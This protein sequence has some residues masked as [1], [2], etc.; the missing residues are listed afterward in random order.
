[1][2]CTTLNALTITVAQGAV[3]V[4]G[5]VTCSG[6]SATFTP[7]SPLAPNAAF[8]AIVTTGAKDLAGVA[9]AANYVWG[10]TTSPILAVTF[11]NPAA[12]ASAADVNTTIQAAFN[13]MMNCATLST[14]TFTVVQAMPD[15]GAAGVAGTVT[16]VASTSTFTP[17]S[18]LASATAFTATIT[19]GV[20]DLAGNTLA[21][22]YVW[23]FTTGTQRSAAVPTVT[24]VTPL[25]GAMGVAIN[26]PV[27]ATFD[28]PMNAATITGAT[29]TVSQVVGDGGVTPIAGTVSLDATTH[30]VAT[31]TPTASYPPSATMTATVTTGAQD[32]AGNGLYQNYVW[33]FQ[34]G[35]QVGQGTIDLG[36]ASTFAILSF[37]TVT[38]VNNVGT[39]VTGDIGI[40]P[41]TALVGFPPGVCNGS[42]DVDTP[43]AEAAETSLL[44]AYNDAVARAHPAAL[45]GDISGLTFTPGLYANLSSV[46]LSAGSV[47]LDAQGDADAVFIFQIST[48]LTTIGGT[49]VVLA[50]GAKATNIFWAV[51]TSATLG[52]TSIFKGT[53]LAAIAITANTGA[54]VEGRLLTQAAAVSL[55]TNIITVPSP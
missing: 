31:F 54:A 55:D 16:C 22:D 46:E 51:G 5:A 45:P 30:T 43:A 13:E 1:M 24:A 53:I 37:N 29:F 21:V 15:A 8:T 9:L 41:G 18:E 10:F 17:T 38:N 42:V 11:T 4:V 48:T 35:T 3:A 36:A 28:E 20:K 52:T 25:N 26:A 7:L 27:T 47:T 44:A 39:Y 6:T 14:T 50:G 34:T 49:E 23:G 19:T 40:Y 2:D 32:G 12:G 33:A